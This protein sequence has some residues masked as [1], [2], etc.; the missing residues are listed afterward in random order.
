MQQGWSSD[1]NFHACS[2]KTKFKKLCLS[3]HVLA[4][5]SCFLHLYQKFYLQRNLH[6]LMRAFLWHIFQ[7]KTITEWTA[8]GYRWQSL[9]RRCSIRNVSFMNRNSLE[10]PCAP[11]ISVRSLYRKFQDLIAEFHHLAFWFA[12]Q[13]DYCTD[14][15]DSCCTPFWGFF[16]KLQAV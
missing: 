4:C 14:P 11:K 7:E 5:R 13:W 8:W 1:A 6:E 12:P 16:S 3:G 15:L 10:M 9:V 2:T